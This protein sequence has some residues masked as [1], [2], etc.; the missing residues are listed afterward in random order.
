MNAWHQMY[1]PGQAIIHPDTWTPRNDTDTGTFSFGQFSFSDF[2]GADGKLKADEDLPPSPSAVVRESVEDV[3]VELALQGVSMLEVDFKEQKVEFPQGIEVSDQLHAAMF[4]DV[5]G[6]E[7]PIAI[8]LK[9]SFNAFVELDDISLTAECLATLSQAD[10]EKE[11]ISD[12]FEFRPPAG[13]LTPGVQITGENINHRNTLDYLSEVV[14]LQPDVLYVPYSGLVKTGLYSKESLDSR[15][16]YITSP[17]DGFDMNLLSTIVPHPEDAVRDYVESRCGDEVSQYDADKNAI[18]HYLWGTPLGTT[19]SGL[20]YLTLAGGS[21][22][23]D[24]GLRISL[25]KM[26]GNVS[27]LL[28]DLRLVKYSSYEPG[29]CVVVLDPAALIGLYISCEFVSRFEVFPGRNPYRDKYYHLEMSSEQAYEEDLLLVQEYVFVKCVGKCFGKKTERT[30]FKYL[31]ARHGVVKISNISESYSSE[32]ADRWKRRILIDPVKTS[33][34]IKR[35][36]IKSVR[37]RAAELHAASRGGYR[38]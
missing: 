32:G 30:I 36:D 26:R 1:K 21:P 28:I 11:I 12:I 7:R 17:I 24:K 29:S 31:V 27:P 34:A 8:E 6:E 5:V 19:P 18:V 33:C 20:T 15:V 22:L 23:S 10:Y 9:E 25:D 35:G 3:Y 13:C 14:G 4:F 2:F 37:L 16:V 38:N